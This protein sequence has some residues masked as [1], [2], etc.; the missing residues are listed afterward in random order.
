MQE[1]WRP[2][3]GLTARLSQVWLNRWTLFLLVVV[4]H[5]LSI[6][7]LLENDLESAKDE[8]LSACLGIEKAGSVLASI[9]HF[10]AQGMNKMTAK[11]IEASLAGLNETYKLTLW[12]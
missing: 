3:L 12:R 4:L 1:S 7:I 8:A 6:M 11:G 2:Y 5:L 10:M 9:P